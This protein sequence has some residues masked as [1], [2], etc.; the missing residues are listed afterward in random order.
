MASEQAPGTV[1]RPRASRRV[2]AR[3]REIITRVSDVDRA[4]TEAAIAKL[5]QHCGAAQLQ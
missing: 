3:N 2:W 4:R 1:P 5:A